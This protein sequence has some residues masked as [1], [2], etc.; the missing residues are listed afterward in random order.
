[1]GLQL[2]VLDN[3]ELPSIATGV[4]RVVASRWPKVDTDIDIT[5]QPTHNEEGI[6]DIAMAKR[7]C[8]FPDENQDFSIYKFYSSDTCTTEVNFVFLLISSSL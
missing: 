5:Q 1:M 2:F 6:Q 4:D 7:N 3:V 8:R